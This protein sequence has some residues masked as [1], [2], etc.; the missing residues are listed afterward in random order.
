MRNSF[1]IEKAINVMRVHDVDKV[2]GVIPEES[3]I[4]KHDGSSLI[5]LD[6][7]HNQ[8]KLR[9]ERDYFYRQTGGISLTKSK[10]LKEKKASTNKVIQGHIILSK[11]AATAISTDLELKIAN[12]ILKASK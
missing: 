5:S 12:T 1:Y 6:N 11:E 10:L 2:I 8:T 3:I 9:L 7:N 4:Y